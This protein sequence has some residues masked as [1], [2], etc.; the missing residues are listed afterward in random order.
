MKISTLQKKVLLWFKQNKRP[1][2][3]RDSNSW[4]EVWISE[5]MLQQTQV[6]TVIPYYHRFLEKFKTV[7]ELAN[8]SQLE[9]KR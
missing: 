9:Q 2:P 3:W 1:L 8:A 7:R 4:Y 6:D 5:V